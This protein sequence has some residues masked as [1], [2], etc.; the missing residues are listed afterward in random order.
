MGAK[1]PKPEELEPAVDRDG[2]GGAQAVECRAPRPVVGAVGK[3]P[4]QHSLRTQVRL[5]GT[6]PHPRNR[7][8]LNSAS[9]G[10][11]E[12]GPRTLG[13]R[14][15]G[16]DTAATATAVAVVASILLLAIMLLLLRVLLRQLLS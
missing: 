15:V 12:A 5:L 14:G 16:G 2:R 3:V 1:S 10:V 4:D 11:E 13:G 9:P 6:D 8:H 7:P